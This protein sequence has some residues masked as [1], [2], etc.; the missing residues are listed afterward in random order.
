[1]PTKEQRG[2]NKP[3]E[4]APSVES[5]ADME[6][7]AEL[8]GCS[9]RGADKGDVAWLGTTAALRSAHLRRFMEGTSTA[10]ERRHLFDALWEL[11]A[12]ALSFCGPDPAMAAA[13]APPPQSDLSLPSSFWGRLQGRGGVYSVLKWIRALGNL[14][15]RKLSL[16]H[17]GLL[18]VLG[19]CP[20]TG[21]STV[22]GTPTQAP[23]GATEYTRKHAPRDPAPLL[24]SRHKLLQER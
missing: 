8:M 1:M 7:S 19:L 5:R 22:T 12:P 15:P 14:K 9:G 18:S 16:P 4:A 2:R 3:R 11:S 23:A 13:T 6:N 24:G 17:F 10:D 20:P 21:S